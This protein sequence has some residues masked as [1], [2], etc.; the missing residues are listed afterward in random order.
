VSKPIKVYTEALINTFDPKEK[1]E[2][3]KEDDEEL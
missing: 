2:K 1:S 3:D